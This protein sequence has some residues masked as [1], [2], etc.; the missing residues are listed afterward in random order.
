[1]HQF[2]KNAA[3]RSSQEEIEL[4]FKFGKF[5]FWYLQVLLSPASYLDGIHGCDALML[6]T[7]SSWQY[8]DIIDLILILGRYSLGDCFRKEAI[9]IPAAP[10]CYSAERPHVFIG[11]EVFPLQAN[12]LRPCPLD[13]T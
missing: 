11:D 9:P 7:N 8:L 10:P 12:P 5:N 2:T 3:Y 6:T 13:L 4:A 1:M